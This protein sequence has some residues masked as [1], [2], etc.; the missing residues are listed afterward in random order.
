MQLFAFRMRSSDRLAEQS[1]EVALR[2]LVLLKVLG[3]DR[4]R[5][6]DEVRFLHV[7]V[8]HL[9]LFPTVVRSVD[10]GH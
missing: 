7:L 6:V 9:A 1:A 10:D 3:G 8:E 2:L 5:I 4:E